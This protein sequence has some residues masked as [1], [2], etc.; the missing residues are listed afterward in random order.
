MRFRLF[1][2]YLAP[3]MQLPLVKNHPAR[4][5]LEHRQDKRDAHDD[6][7]STEHHHG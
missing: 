3:V 5:V 4:F 6:G 7:C 2:V 1:L